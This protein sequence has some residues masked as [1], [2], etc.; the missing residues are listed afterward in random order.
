M[1]TPPEIDD[2]WQVSELCACEN[3]D[4]RNY[5]DDMAH[6]VGTTRVADQDDIIAYAIVFAYKIICFNDL[7]T[8]ICKM[9]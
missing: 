5:T 7:L 6:C 3:A 8:E 9:V 2:D 4:L 1:V